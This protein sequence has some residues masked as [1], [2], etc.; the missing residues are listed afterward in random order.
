ML[1]LAVWSYNIYHNIGWIK[2]WLT[3]TLMTLFMEVKLDYK[4][5]ISLVR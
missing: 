5:L 2:S 1:K 4:I 3:G